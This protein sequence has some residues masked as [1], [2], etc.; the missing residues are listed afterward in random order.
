MERCEE[1]RDIWK[2][3]RKALVRACMSEEGK[4]QECL[5]GA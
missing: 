4:Y 5:S 2:K 1:I 3:E